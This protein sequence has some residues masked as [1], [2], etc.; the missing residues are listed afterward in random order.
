MAISE[1]SILYRLSSFYEK[2]IVQRV[3]INL[4][5]LKGNDLLLSG[6]DSVLMNVWEEICVQTQNE[7]SFHWNLYEDLIKNEISLEFNKL[8]TEIRTLLNYQG[9]IEQ[10]EDVETEKELYDDFG[11]Q[12]LCLA[13]ETASLD[14]TNRRISRYLGNDYELF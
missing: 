6:N 8:P 4:K 11:I 1:F 5:K 12:L 13:V 3:I 9:S 10:E 2:K 14:Y 7:E